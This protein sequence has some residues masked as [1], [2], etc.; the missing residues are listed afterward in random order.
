MDIWGFTRTT[1]FVISTEILMIKKSIHLDVVRLFTLAHVPPYMAHDG[2]LGATS[3]QI[4]RLILNL[5]PAGVYP[6]RQGNAKL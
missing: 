2:F 1:I 3:T 5:I 4:Y 6:A